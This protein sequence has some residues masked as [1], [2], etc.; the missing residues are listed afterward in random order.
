MLRGKLRW[1]FA[2]VTT[3]F[4][5]FTFCIMKICCAR[6]WKYA[7]QTISTCNATLLRD[8]LHEKFCFLQHENLLRRKV[9]IRASNHLN[10]QR[11]IAA[12]QI[13]RKILLFATWKFL[14]KKV[15][16]RAS[17]HLNLQR[18]IVARQVA[19]KSLPVLLGLKE[20]LHN[21]GAKVAPE[22][23]HSGSV[24]WLCIRLLG[25]TRKC[26]IPE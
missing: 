22:R 18:N 21:T 2:R 24:L 5:A 25:T 23:V 9:V 17:N 14:R 26:H 13:A 19:R 1:F 12:R 20:R 6:R 11:N 7:H 10:L 3:F 16:I 8:K 15:V 4:V